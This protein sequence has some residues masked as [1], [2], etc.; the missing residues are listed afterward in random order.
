MTNILVTGAPKTGKTTL[1]ANVI[2]ESG[3]RPIGFI[4]E[5][6]LQDHIRIG[7]QI[8]TYSGTTATLA[9]VNN[10]SSR[11]L[12]G[13]YGVFLENLDEIVGVLEA[14]MACK[15]YDLV[16]IDEIGKMELGSEAFKQFIL[17]CLDLGKVFGSIMLHDNFFTRKIKERPD[18]VVYHLTRNN[19]EDIKN[20][21]LEALIHHLKY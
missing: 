15:Q 14:E 1:I 6:V 17:R 10:R 2:K 5:E 8:R 12:V 13:K 4:T 11:Y 18:T 3:F 20:Q 9:S 19:R 21:V 7:F 16:V